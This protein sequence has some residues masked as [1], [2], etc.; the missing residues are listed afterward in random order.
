MRDVR[1]V[2]KDQL[3]LLTREVRTLEKERKKGTSGKSPFYYS[4]EI[5]RL[6]KLRKFYMVS[7]V[8][9]VKLD[10]GMV[11]NGTLLDQIFKRI[12]HV[13]APVITEGDG[14]LIIEYKT[15]SGHGKYTLVDISK[16]YD[17]CS[18]PE[19]SLVEG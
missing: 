14:E 3:N 16:Y 11:V 17:K 6:E 12:P 10:N 5:E 13:P 15:S 2:M 9:P 1:E 19:R 18:I 8:K 4:N 7:K